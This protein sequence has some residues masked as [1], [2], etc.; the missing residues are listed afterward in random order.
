M[1][2]RAPAGKSD[3]QLEHLADIGEPQLKQNLA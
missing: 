3:W 2:K 1:Q